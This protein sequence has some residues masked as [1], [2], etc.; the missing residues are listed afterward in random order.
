LPGRLSALLAAAAALIAVAGCG[1]GEDDTFE[2][3]F[4]QLSRQVA[5][6]GE[7]VGEAIETA[8]ESSDRELAEEFDRF[9]QKLGELRQQIDDLEPPEELADER[10]ELVA[11]MGE[12][13][14]SL[15]DIAGAAERSDP[16]AAR[17]AT[18]ELIDNSEQLRDARQE[19]TRAVREGE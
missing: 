13:R 5:S 8:G 6:L 16:E 15:E 7:D 4:P 10:D 11:A 18:L 2:D 3:E 1:G 19:L 17:E 12:V 9:A 14:G